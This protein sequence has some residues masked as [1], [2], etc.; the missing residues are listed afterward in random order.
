MGYY[1]LHGSTKSIQCAKSMAHSRTAR[2]TSAAAEFV[3]SSISPERWRLDTQLTEDVI[4]LLF[5]SRPLPGENFE[6]HTAAAPIHRW[7]EAEGGEEVHATTERRSG[8]V[9]SSAAVGSNIEL[10]RDAFHTLCTRLCNN[11]VVGVVPI[12]S[13][14]Y[15]TSFRSSRS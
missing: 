5:R 3:S 8:K 7:T 2:N 11:D 4:T 10:Q 9:R 1:R 14:R 13:A 15:V 6:S 12:A